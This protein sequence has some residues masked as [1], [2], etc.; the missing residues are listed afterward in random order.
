MRSLC[1]SLFRSLVG[2]LT[3]LLVITFVIAVDPESFWT[4]ILFGVTALVLCWVASYRSPHK[5]EPSI[6]AAILL[7][8]FLTTMPWMAD[9]I[10]TSLLFSICF[11]CVAV[12]SFRSKC[13]CGNLWNNQP[14][15]ATKVITILY[16]LWVGILGLY[17]ILLVLHLGDV[18]L[19]L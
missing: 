10:L 18:I 11:A 19:L 3:W 8:A 7:V 17:L 16:W 13:R 5:G 15:L 9:G 6:Y 1:L 4:R 12:S 2:L 14:P